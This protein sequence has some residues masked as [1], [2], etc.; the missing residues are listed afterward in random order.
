MEKIKNFNKERKICEDCGTLLNPHGADVDRQGQIIMKY[1]CK[2]CKK[3]ISKETGIY[4]DYTYPDTPQCEKCGNALIRDGVRYSVLK[5]KIVVC[6]FCKN[7]R[8]KHS[9]YIDNF[10]LNGK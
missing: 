9:I 2:T 6:M 5:D 3:M 1:R 8:K 4:V 10:S 7:C